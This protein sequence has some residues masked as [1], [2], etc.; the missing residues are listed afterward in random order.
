MIFRESLRDFEARLIGR[1]HSCA[2]GLR[3]NVTRAN[4]AYQLNP[5]IFQ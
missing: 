5:P 2:M 3:G 4:L 1:R